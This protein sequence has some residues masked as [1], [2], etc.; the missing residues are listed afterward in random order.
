MIVGLISLGRWLATIRDM[1]NLRPLL[2]DALINETRQLV[3]AIFVS[4]T[5]AGVIVRFLQHQHPWVFV[6]ARGGKASRA[7]QAVMRPTTEQA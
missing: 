7:P 4:A 6:S 1:P 2:C 5:G 3:P